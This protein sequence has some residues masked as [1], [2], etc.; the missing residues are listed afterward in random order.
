MS[1][2]GGGKGIVTP[3]PPPFWYELLPS[4]SGSDLRYFDGELRLLIS[5]AAHIGNISGDQTPVSYSS[6]LIALLWSDDSTSSWFQKFSEQ[7][8]VSQNDIYN[9]RG[10][11]LEYQ[12]LV[13]KLSYENKELEKPF[14]DFTSS[15]ARAMLSNTFA[16]TDEVGSSNVAVVGVRHL[17]AAFAFRNPSYHEK[18]FNNWN[19]DEQLLRSEFAQYIQDNYADEYQAWYGL[20]SDYVESLLPEG[21]EEYDSGD[22][23]GSYKLEKDAVT[24]LRLVEG[25]SK[26]RSLG[27]MNSELTL[28]ILLSSSS[29]ALEGA[30]NLQAALDSRQPAIL[31]TIIKEL[32]VGE[33]RTIGYIDESFE[34]SPTD[35]GVSRGLKRTLD[36][37]RTYTYTTNS[38]KGVDIH[39]IV[40][41]ILLHPDTYAH[42]Y[43]TRVGIDFSALRRDML[44]SIGRSRL[45]DDGVAWN[46]ILVG[47]PPIMVTPYKSDS[48]NDGEDCLDISRYARAFATVMAVK[49]NKPPMSIGIFGDWGSGKSFFM[50][51]MREKAKEITQQTDI[52]E[53]GKRVFCENILPVEFNA[54]HYAETN[55]WASLVHTILSELDSALHKDE[56]QLSLLKDLRLAKAAKEYADKEIAKYERKRGIVLKHFEEVQDFHGKC[57]KNHDEIPSKLEILAAA[58]KEIIPKADKEIDNAL[59]SAEEYL[60]IEGAKIMKRSVGDLSKLL[61]EV[62]Q[63]YA[64]GK[65]HWAWLKQSHLL[66]S[67]L[68]TAII[69]LVLVTIG[70]YVFTQVT[71]VIDWVNVIVVEFLSIAGA[72]ALCGRRLIDKVQ[73]GLSRLGS[74][75]SRIDMIE[76]GK[77]QQRDAK[78]EA[79]EKQLK[80]AKER[81][82]ASKRALDLA[83]DE[84]S[85]VQAALDGKSSISQIA[86][87]IEGRLAG[88][89][90]EQYLSIVSM[91]RSDFETLSDYFSGRKQIPDKNIH[92]NKIDRI[93]LYI[94]DL[95]RCPSDQVV[96]VLE[97]VHLML[98][99]D[100]FIVVV[101]VDMRWASI[102]LH[103]HYPAHLSSLDVN[104]HDTNNADEAG[105]DMIMEQLQTA[106]AMDYLE[107]IFQIPFWLPPMQEKACR[108]LL[109][110][111]VPESSTNQEDEEDVLN[112]SEGT[113]GQSKSTP[114]SAGA[115]KQG[116]VE[117]ILSQ[118][119]SSGNISV[120]EFSDIPTDEREYML[121]L[122]S[123]V[124]RSPRRLKRFVN[125]YRILKA[126]CDPL[127]R[128]DLVQKE[129]YRAVMTL[130]AI[131]T[132]AP[133]AAPKILQSLNGQEK[134]YKLKDLREDIK[135]LSNTFIGGEVQYVLNALSV[136]EHSGK[137]EF[138]SIKTLKEWVAKTAHFSF[139]SGG[140]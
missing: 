121:S 54:W 29:S 28:S 74:L 89:D 51:L 120:A 124:G 138:E 109:A 126:S 2:T 137:P 82:S 41:A 70:I 71:G 37:A 26:E 130:L 31:S 94:D 97:A 80:E 34:V 76:Q 84:V 61:D 101:G 3:P 67:M 136:Y 47:V 78:F 50:R 35:L 128:E 122:A 25:L 14:K 132:G 110:D 79:A 33:D 68:T 55:L 58:A 56:R 46:T 106:S 119:V 87:L 12:G 57:V 44:D 103:E 134:V 45:N 135:S 112:S 129:E 86:G 88:K 123:S 65:S 40:A 73:Y 13:S 11:S 52:N 53:H 7:H 9:H 43:M 17:V 95:D 69:A 38:R 127:E 32:G 42:D 19:I 18:D 113:S 98:A 115:Q 27:V 116:T 102:S 85:R 48:A 125:S 131:I 91:I 4:I 66:S 140:L 105:D 39:H 63:Q 139:R 5:M 59:S 8:G 22:V 90:Y 96:K 111:L 1:M 108:D 21:S 100:L 62:N 99:F 133:K 20:L 49:D 6:L 16:I 36:R 60:G 72:L 93:V 15:S 118:P 104:G 10:I 81:L 77:I 114:L 23:L 75:R 117:G 64:E 83:E 107:K 24:L 92:L 30:I